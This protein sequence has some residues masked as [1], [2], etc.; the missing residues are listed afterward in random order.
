MAY[1]DGRVHT[2]IN[3]TPCSKDVNRCFT[4]ANLH[5]WRLNWQMGTSSGGTATMQFEDVLAV[6]ESIAYRSDRRPYCEGIIQQASHYGMVP[7]PS[8]LL[9]AFDIPGKYRV[10]YESDYAEVVDAFWRLLPYRAGYPMWYRDWPPVFPEKAHSCTGS[11]LMPKEGP[12]P[13]GPRTIHSYVVVGRV[14]R[15]FLAGCNC[16]VNGAECQHYKG[17]YGDIC[18]FLGM[19]EPLQMT[20]PLLRRRKKDGTVAVISAGV[21]VNNP[22]YVYDAMQAGV[23]YQELWGFLENVVFPPKLP[24]GQRGQYTQVTHGLNFD[25]ALEQYPVIDDEAWIDLLETARARKAK[26]SAE[27]RARIAE[28]NK[29]AAQ[30][31]ARAAAAHEEEAIAARAESEAVIEQR[32]GEMAEVMVDTE[33]KR[34]ERNRKRRERRAQEK[35]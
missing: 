32:A 3:I 14:V 9:E 7:S 11:L 13:A 22:Y 18:R 12:G 23:T 1:N 25:L 16:F 21:A 2:R 4:I 26:A 17:T 15:D 10:Q 20:A 27:E 31:A 5:M 30:E 29:R 19:P 34:L 33:V 8:E 35:H 6:N 28:K 24:G